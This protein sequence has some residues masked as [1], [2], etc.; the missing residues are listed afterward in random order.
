MSTEP[1]EPSSYYPIKK[2][3]ARQFATPQDEMIYLLRSMRAMLIFFT[4]LTVLGL[5]AGIVSVVDLIHA[6]NNSGTTGL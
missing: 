4:V 3:P 5:I 6:A 1:E 2:T